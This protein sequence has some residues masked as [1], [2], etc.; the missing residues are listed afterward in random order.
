MNLRGL[1]NLCKTPR[2]D[3]IF[4]RMRSAPLAFLPV[5]LAT[6][7]KI[8][9]ASPIQERRAHPRGVLQR[10]P[11]LIEYNQDPL[12]ISRPEGFPAGFGTIFSANRPLWPSTHPGQPFL[13]PMPARSAWAS[14]GDGFLAAVF[15]IAGL[16]VHRKRRVC[17]FLGHLM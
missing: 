3:C 12:K 4:S 10:F 13:R 11:G 6:G 15:S 16:L 17:F 9:L 14:C 1:G 7:C 5:V 8:C 2:G